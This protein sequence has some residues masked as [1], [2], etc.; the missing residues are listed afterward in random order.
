MKM[1]LMNAAVFAHRSASRRLVQAIFLL[2]QFASAAAAF[3]LSAAVPGITSQPADESR[4][5]GEN[6]AFSVVVSNTTGAGYQWY[7]EN[8][9]LSSRTNATL[10]LVGVSTNSAGHFSVVITNMDGATTSRVATVTVTQ[11]DFGPQAL[12]LNNMTSYRGQNGLLVNV[13]VTGSLGGGVWGTD[14]YTDDSTLAAAAVH[15]GYLTNGELGTLIVEILPGQSSYTGSTRNGVSTFSY[16]SWAGSFQIV[17]LAPAFVVEPFSHVA[18]TG[19]S[20]V[21]SAQA[22]A[23]DSISY[24]WKHNGSP[25]NWQTKSSLTLS[26][27][28]ANDAGTY[29]VTAWTTTA[30][31]TSETATLVVI[32]PDPGS[33]PVNA[34]YYANGLSYLDGE[35][36]RVIVTGS[37]NPGSLYGSGIYT[38]DSALSLAAVHSGVLAPDEPG[39]LALLL[40][41]AQSQFIGSTQNGL[42]SAARGSPYAAFGFLAL[43]PT[44]TQHPVGQGVLPGG[45]AG[46]SVS[47]TSRTGPLRYQWR[48]NG[49]D[50]LDQTNSTLSLNNLSSADSGQ[51]DALVSNPDGSTVSLPAP[52]VVSSPGTIPQ[53]GTS[54][55]GAT[56]GAIIFAA[57]V[58]TT[59][60]G[61]WGDGVYTCDSSLAAAA[62]HAGVLT[63]GQAGAVAVIALPGQTQ[64]QSSTR[65]GVTS[66]AWASFYESYSFVGLAPYITG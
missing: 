22:T 26:N 48:H 6:A 18:W 60:G 50:L 42:T 59:N 62:V 49:A 51:Y 7:L 43:T 15:A 54:V 39:T 41:P 32:D 66:S 28:T 56:N 29:A 1:V 19:A 38:L 52:L 37:T 46:F 27:L 47:A 2:I 13:T 12:A 61:L 55:C 57:V 3:H 20:V 31:N 40:L 4:F 44:I 21:F 33:P 45:S 36:Y 63:N 10:T 30:T 11:P 58:G 24:Q 23:R 8:S 17:G 64:Y 9:P 5:V 53:T 16:G 25:L 34:P 14:I 65:N 35:V